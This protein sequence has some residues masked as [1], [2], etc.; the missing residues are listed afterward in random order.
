MPNFFEFNP[1]QAFL[2]PPNLRDVLKADNLCFF[3]HKVVERLDM[4]AFAG[5][6]LFTQLRQALLLGLAY[7]LYRLWHPAIP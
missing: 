5:R 6:S 4:G 3:L 1:E 2:L 7:N